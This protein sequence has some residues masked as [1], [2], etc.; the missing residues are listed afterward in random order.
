VFALQFTGD[1]KAL[2][3]VTADRQGVERF[4]LAKLALRPK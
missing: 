2:V 1:S 3:A 4:D